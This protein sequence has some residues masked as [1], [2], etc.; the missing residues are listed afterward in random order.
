[1]LPAARAPLHTSQVPPS[2]NQVHPILP[3]ALLEAVR[4]LDVPPGADLDEFHREL[5]VKRLGTSRTVV[6]QIGRYAQLVSAGRRI[7]GD[8]L[9]AVLRLV[10]RRADAALAFANAGRIAGRRAARLASPL[11]RALR[12]ASVGGPGRSLG[13]LIARRAARVVL[14]AD[15]ARPGGVYQATLAGAPAA[16]VVS[17]E[18]ACG[19]FGAALAELLRTFTDFD[20]ALFHTECRARGAVVCRWT[21]SARGE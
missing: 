7:E 19:F 17:V 1:M 5:T 4:E 10:G 12:R 20:G 15:L 21:S 6:A 2:P 16:V 13:F 14:A 3:L 11:M 8:E 18:S 9:A